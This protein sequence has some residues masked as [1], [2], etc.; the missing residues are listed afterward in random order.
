MEFT[1]HI[2]SDFFRIDDTIDKDIREVIGFSR[3]QAGEFDV[4]RRTATEANIVQGASQLRVDE[5][6]DLVAD[7]IGEVFQDK[8]NP[9]IYQNWT[10]R[11]VIEV[12]ELGGWVTYTGDM[13]RGDY[14]LSVVPDSVLPLNKSQEQQLAVQA[15]N[16]FRGDP[17]VK[18]R[19]LYMRVMTAFRDLLPSPEQLLEDPQV[20][21]QKM[22]QQQLI[23]QLQQQGG[24]PQG[25]PTA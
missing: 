12:T 14:S 25:A 11:R 18:Q 19:D 21:Q 23:N 22:Q 15:F 24:V 8:I 13:I 4:P 16:M 7:L 3:N 6:R 17:W 5:R 9:L 20:L 2:P 1:T 10:E